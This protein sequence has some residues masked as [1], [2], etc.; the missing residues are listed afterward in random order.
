MMNLKDDCLKDE[1]CLKYG[2]GWSHVILANAII[3]VLLFCNLGC[4]IMG[5]IRPKWRLLAS[6]LGFLLCLAHLGAIV[7][8]AIFRFRT[9]GALC[10]LYT[11][12][13]NYTTSKVTTLND[14]WTFEKDGALILALWVFQILGA[15]VCCLLASY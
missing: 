2:T 13:N 11:V 5:R 8:V 12:P 7:T 9:Q 4:I 3:M 1:A 15:P 14:D 6:Y 10:S